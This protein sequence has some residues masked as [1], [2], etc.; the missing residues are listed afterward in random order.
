MIETEAGLDIKQS[1]STVA[2]STIKETTSG[3]TE[4]TQSGL[5]IAFNKMGIL[6]DQ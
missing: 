4:E 1:T 2:L 3:E 6:H 5:E